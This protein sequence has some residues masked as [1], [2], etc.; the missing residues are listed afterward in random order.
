MSGRRLTF[1]FTILPDLMIQ[2]IGLKNNAQHC[3]ND[4][5]YEYDYVQ[6]KHIDTP[7]F[8]RIPMKDELEIRFTSFPGAM[9]FLHR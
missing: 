8:M 3:T 2:A 6:S 7:P 4:S 5:Q 1:F 9:F